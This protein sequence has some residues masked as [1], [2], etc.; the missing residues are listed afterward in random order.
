MRYTVSA[1]IQYSFTRNADYRDFF[2]RIV[3]T[4]LAWSWSTYVPWTK[5]QRVADSQKHDNGKSQTILL[6]P[7]NS[8]EHLHLRQR[9]ESTWF[10]E[11]KNTKRHVVNAIT[12]QLSRL[13]KMR[14][15]KQNVKNEVLQKKVEKEQRIR[16]KNKK[17]AKKIMKEYNNWMW[18][19][20]NAKKYA[21]WM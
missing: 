2:E 3:P 16:N 7:W 12:K 8:S 14:R 13:L 21:K 20:K 9:S 18:K 10:L 11:E 17:R 4:V 5:E 1:L 15:G 6:V 19:I